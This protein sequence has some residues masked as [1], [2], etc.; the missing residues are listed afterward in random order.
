V[1]RAG[2][3]DRVL[4]EQRPAGRAERLRRECLDDLP[5]GSFLVLAEEPASI[6]AVR[7]DRLLCWTP[8]GYRAARRR[9]RAAAVDVLTP[10]AVVAALSAGYA[11]VW[12]PTA[13]S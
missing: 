3:I 5:D 13:G 6:F 2:G 8:A 9:P 1:P 7:G 11:P 10:P 4:H 12:H